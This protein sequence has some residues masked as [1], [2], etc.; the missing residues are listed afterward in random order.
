MPRFMTENR[1]GQTVIFAQRTDDGLGEAAAGEAGAPTGSSRRRGG[2]GFGALHAGKTV[3]HQVPAGKTMSRPAIFSALA[4][5][6]CS[7]KALLR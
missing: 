4:S 6:Y 7:M 2:I 5:R 1:G 3:N